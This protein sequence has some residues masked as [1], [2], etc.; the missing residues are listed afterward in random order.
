MLSLF[1]DEPPRATHKDVQHVRKTAQHLRDS[2]LINKGKTIKT[3]RLNLHY[4]I[5]FQ[6]CYT[7][8]QKNNMFV[9]V[10]IQMRNRL[11]IAEQNMFTIQLQFCEIVSTAILIKLL[12]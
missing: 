5:W 11:F 1:G 4:R 8:C 3:Q 7:R 6:F 2:S 12:E 9:K 10:T